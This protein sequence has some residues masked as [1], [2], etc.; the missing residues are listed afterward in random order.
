MFGHIEISVSWLSFP[1]VGSPKHKVLE[2]GLLNGHVQLKELSISPFGGIRLERSSL[3]LS[4]R[5]VGAL[6]ISKTCSPG[7][8]GYGKVTGLGW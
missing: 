1:S 2:V 8:G 5:V 3:S 6:D 4:T 7:S